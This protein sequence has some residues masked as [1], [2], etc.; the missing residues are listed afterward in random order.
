METSYTKLLS[1]VPHRYTGNLPTAR[2][3]SRKEWQISLCAEVE[4]YIR[5]SISG[6]IVR[7]NDTIEGF[8][9]Q[10]RVLA[11]REG[12]LY[13]CELLVGVDRK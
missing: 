2:M 6:A 4:R 3:I 9:P 13:G 11:S 1:K 8:Q 12:A 7:R 10:D 5:H